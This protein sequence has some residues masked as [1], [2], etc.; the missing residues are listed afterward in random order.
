MTKKE[1]LIL[2]NKRYREE[3]TKEEQDVIETKD[4]CFFV[5]GLYGRE[6]VKSEEKRIGK[7]GD[8][9]RLVQ[10]AL[11][12]KKK[13]TSLMEYIKNKLVQMSRTEDVRPGTYIAKLVSYLALYSEEILGEEYYITENDKQIIYAGMLSD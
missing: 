8:A 4:F 12:S 6:V 2:L 10:H 3:M 1:A 7:S 13:R 5:V 9:F 11:N